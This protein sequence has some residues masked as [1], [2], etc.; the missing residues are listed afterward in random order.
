[1]LRGLKDFID[2]V[3]FDLCCVEDL[4]VVVVTGFVLDSFR[5]TCTNAADKPRLFLSSLQANRSFFKSLSRYRRTRTQQQNQHTE[6]HGNNFALNIM[7]LHPDKKTHI[8]PIFYQTPVSK[9]PTPTS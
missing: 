7:D 9:L 1:M 3:A 8:P 5:Q 2:R 6:A 4:Y